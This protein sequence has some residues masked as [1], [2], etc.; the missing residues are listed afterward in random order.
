L[1]LLQ[2]AGL[3]TLDLRVGHMEGAVT[4][5]AGGVQCNIPVAKSSNP[6]TISAGDD[7][8]ISISIPS[9]ANLFNQ[10]FGCDLVNISAVDV[11]A[12]TGGK[13]TGTRVFDVEVTRTGVLPSTGGDGRLLVLGGLLLLTALAVQ[14]RVRKPAAKS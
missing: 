8:T 9:D 5:P 3:N 6:A 11:H 4:V 10:L 1:S 13:V 7:F 12:V 14:R 2:L